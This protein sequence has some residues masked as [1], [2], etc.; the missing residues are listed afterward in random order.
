MSGWANDSLW[1]IKKDMSFKKLFLACTIAFPDIIWT[2][3]LR[4]SYSLWSNVKESS[5]FNEKINKNRKET[6]LRHFVVNSFDSIEHVYVLNKFWIKVQL[7]IKVN[8]FINLNT[9]EIWKNKISRGMSL[10]VTRTKW[11]KKKIKTPITNVYVMLILTNSPSKCKTGL[12][13]LINDVI[14]SFTSLYIAKYFLY[15]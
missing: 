3:I 15:Q 10:Y 5:W 2:E 4:I 8:W 11:N 1:I 13:E 9:E 12:T 14:I 6:V 7:S